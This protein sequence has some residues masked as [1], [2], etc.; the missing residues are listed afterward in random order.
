MYY[1]IVANVSLIL[2]VASR[3]EMKPVVARCEQ[4]V[5][6][7]ANTLD[8]DRLFQ[9]TCAVSHCDPNSSTMSV[10]VDKLASI[11]EAVYKEIKGCII[12]DNLEVAYGEEDLSR[13]QFSQMP[14]DV[15]AEVYTQK[16]RERERK[17]Q[18]WCCF[19]S[20]MESFN[21]GGDD[22]LLRDVEGI[23]QRFRRIHIESFTLES[24]RNF[25]IKLRII[26]SLKNVVISL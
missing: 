20:W 26:K 8:R 24:G 14:G 17:R 15:V 1:F 2:R 7:S 11:K 18:L 23:K 3:F 13:M 19:A 16:F 22:E 10:L 4:F 12:A 6:R 5:A 25:F 21:D 9:V